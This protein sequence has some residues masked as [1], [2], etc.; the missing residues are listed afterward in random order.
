MPF[1]FRLLQELLTPVECLMPFPFRLLQELLTPVECLMPVDVVGRNYEGRHI[2]GE[3]EMGIVVA[4]KLFLDTRLTKVLVDLM[5][6]VLQVRT[7][8]G[9]PM[10][11]TTILFDLSYAFK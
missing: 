5:T 10:M 4:K 7:G 9:E 11:G 3:L 6:Q 8:V 1:P 2:V